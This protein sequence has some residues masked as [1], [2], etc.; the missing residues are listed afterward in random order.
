MSL[1]LQQLLGAM[2]FF[3]FLVWAGSIWVD[4]M[5][6]KTQDRCTA[7]EQALGECEP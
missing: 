1:R 6:E 2:L 7:T 3:A 4:Q 5:M